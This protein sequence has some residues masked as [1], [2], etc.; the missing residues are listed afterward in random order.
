MLTAAQAPTFQ[1]FKQCT[2]FHYKLSQQ[3][4]YGTT[5]CSLTSATLEF[6]KFPSQ[7]K[8]DHIQLNKLHYQSKLQKREALQNTINIEQKIFPGQNEYLLILIKK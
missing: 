1:N 6:Q 8:T 7:N 4:T 2:G 5:V 3:T